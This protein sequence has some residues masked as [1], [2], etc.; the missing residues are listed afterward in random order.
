MN[1]IEQIKAVCNDKQLFEEISVLAMKNIFSPVATKYYFFSLTPS[2]VFAETE[3]EM[4]LAN[5]VHERTTH[6]SH[7]TF[8]LLAF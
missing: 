1:Y 3:S 5:F 2:C 8:S 7:V 4:K 6:I